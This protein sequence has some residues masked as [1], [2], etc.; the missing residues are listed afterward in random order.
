MLY[1]VLETSMSFIHPAYLLR[2]TSGLKHHTLRY[3]TVLYLSIPIYLQYF[4][5]PFYSGHTT[6]IYSDQ[7]SPHFS[8][9]GPF[10]G[11]N[12]L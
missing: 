11:F 2:V 1:G 4:L 5:F 3:R 8:G 9:L 7:D 10:Q 12:F 6:P